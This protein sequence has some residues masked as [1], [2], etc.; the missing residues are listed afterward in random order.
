MASPAPQNHFWAQHH[1]ILLELLLPQMTSARDLVRLAQTCKAARGVVREERVASLWLRRARFGADAI[2]TDAVAA[3]SAWTQIQRRAA[4]ERLGAREAR[5]LL[6]PSTQA[7]P[8]H[9]GLPRLP[10]RPWTGLCAV[11]GYVVAMDIDGDISLWDPARQGQRDGIP[12]GKAGEI[13]LHDFAAWGPRLSRVSSHHVAAIGNGTALV[14]KITRSH[15]LLYETRTKFQWPISPTDEEEHN[16]CLGVCAISAGGRSF[17]VG[18]FRRRVRVWAP[19]PYGSCPTRNGTLEAEVVRGVDH[20]YYRAIAAATANS[21]LFVCAGTDPRQ[22]SVVEL[23]RYDAAHRAVVALASVTLDGPRDFRR[24]ED[25]GDDDDDDDDDVD[26]DELDTTLELACQGP[27]VVTASVQDYEFQ[28]MP[29]TRV[30]CLETSA[31]RGGGD[32]MRVSRFAIQGYLL[33]GP[34]I[35]DGLVVCAIGLP[36]EDAREFAS[37]ILVCDP[38]AGAVVA[39]VPTPVAV[40]GFSVFPLASLA[41]TCRHVVFASSGTDDAALGNVPYGLWCYDLFADAARDGAAALRETAAPD[42]FA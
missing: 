12:R 16:V 29:R 20:I 33:A 19:T 40:S 28:Q 15:G 14:M 34:V 9:P 17:F 6:P 3:A 36:G 18:A 41:V 35:S 7:P 30:D 22:R 38:R 32:V 37:E 1:S 23:N 24:L 25:S 2:A 39:R 11:G 4:L 21:D 31:C 5:E 8:R 42:P 13:L 26:E 27:L 10:M